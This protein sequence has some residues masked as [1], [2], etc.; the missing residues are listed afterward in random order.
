M[1]SA[2][3]IGDDFWSQYMWQPSQSATVLLGFEAKTDM[4]VASWTATGKERPH[5]KLRNRNGV[6]S[7]RPREGER[8]PILWQEHLLFKQESVGETKTGAWPGD[9]AEKCAAKGWSGIDYR[10]I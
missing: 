4:A 8:R 9:S 5:C 6:A 2:I 7:E 1:I 3:G 10:F